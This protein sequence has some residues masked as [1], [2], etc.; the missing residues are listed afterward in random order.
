MEPNNIK[1][2]LILHEQIDDDM[3]GLSNPSI[4]PTKDKDELIDLLKQ[5]VARLK[6]RLNELANTPDLK[7]PLVKDIYKED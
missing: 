7:F 4:R 6:K 1:N 2:R 3:C 5:E